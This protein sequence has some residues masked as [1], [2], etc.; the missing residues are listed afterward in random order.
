MFTQLSGY[1][2]RKDVTQDAILHIKRPDFEWA[3]LGPK[4]W[5][6]W[7]GIGIL[8]LISWLPW[9]WQLALGGQLGLLLG[10][11]A[12]SRTNVAKRNLELAFPDMPDTERA[13]ILRENLKNTGIALLEGG[14]G[15]WWP[16]WRVRGIGRVEGYE[17]IQAIL[18]KG[19]GVFGIA[20]H[21]LNLEMNCRVIGTV[22]PS[23]VFYRR[24]NNPLME[25]IQYRGRSRAN[26]LMI[27]KKGVREML[28]CLNDGDLCLYL[29][30]QDYGARRSEF[31]PF[32]AVPDAATTTGTLIFAR[33][34]NCESVFVLPLRT[35][36]GY[37]IKILPGL[38]GFPSMDDKLDVTRINQKVEELV[39]QAP[40]QYLWMHKRYKT[41]PDSS[42]PSYYG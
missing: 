42:L 33:E 32:F 38:E 28:N 12:K 13:R 18:D 37:V 10:K 26:K 21:N 31:V 15:W 14:M 6:T 8:Y 41:R 19:K 11:L 4:Y 27:H 29:P 16:D 1:N 34:A 9:R 25:W 20:I 30:D 24:H 17:H 3:F 23:V 35:D 22:H 5:L 39:M 36:D 2:A 7:L 40:E